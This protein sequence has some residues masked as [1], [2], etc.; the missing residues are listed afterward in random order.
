MHPLAVTR[1]FWQTV[2]TR[3]ELEEAVTKFAS[4]AEQ[5]LRQKGNH[6]GQVSCFIRSSPFKKQDA[7]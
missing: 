2:H 5:K 7:Q 1:S 3:E 4:W 6:Q